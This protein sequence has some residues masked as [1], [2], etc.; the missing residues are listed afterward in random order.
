[1]RQFVYAVASHPNVRCIDLTEIDVDRDAADERTVRLAALL[2][3]EAMAG[4]AKRNV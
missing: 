3:L 1:M 2:V 4:L